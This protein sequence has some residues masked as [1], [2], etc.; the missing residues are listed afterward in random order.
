MNFVLQMPSYFSVTWNVLWAIISIYFID[1]REK[2]PA[3]ILSTK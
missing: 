1:N 2:H 3:V